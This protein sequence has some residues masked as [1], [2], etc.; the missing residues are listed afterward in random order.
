MGCAC[1]ALLFE[2]QPNQRFNPTLCRGPVWGVIIT[3]RA[4]QREL[5]WALGGE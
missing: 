3:V 1:A 2:T 4:A 5:T